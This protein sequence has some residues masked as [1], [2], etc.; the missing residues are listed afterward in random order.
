MTPPKVTHF[1]PW[2]ARGDRRAQAVCG[3]VV[4]RRTEHAAAPT[5]PVCVRKQAEYEALQL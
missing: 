2:D 1:V 4:D 3:A 5:C